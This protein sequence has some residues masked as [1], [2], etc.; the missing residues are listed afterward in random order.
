MYGTG[1]S[2]LCLSAATLAIAEKRIPDNV[3]LG[4]STFLDFYQAN[5]LVTDVL[6]HTLQLYHSFRISMRKQENVAELYDVIYAIERLIVPATQLLNVQLLFRGH[7]LPP[8]IITAIN[9]NAATVTTRI[10]YIDIP[11][12]SVFNELCREL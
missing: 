4:I 10:S 2:T 7:Y 6:H 8:F 5:Y 9:T 3:I 12:Y 1:T 11:F